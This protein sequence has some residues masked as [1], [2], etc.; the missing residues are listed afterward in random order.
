MFCYTPDVEKTM[1]Q[2]N[3]AVD[4]AMK[5]AFGAAQDIER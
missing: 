3:A 4:G 5:G 2:A 1:A